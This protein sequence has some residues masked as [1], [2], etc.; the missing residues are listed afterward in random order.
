MRLCLGRTESPFQPSLLVLPSQPFSILTH[1]I[2]SA[3][4]QQGVELRGSPLIWLDFQNGRVPRSKLG[5]LSEY[6]TEMNEPRQM[7]CTVV[8]SFKM[9]WCVE[10]NQHSAASYRKF[11]VHFLASDTE[12]A[13]RR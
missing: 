9:E 2:F 7:S 11:P 1:P 8:N 13:L 10:E 12:M 6:S 3:Q 5:P 4:M